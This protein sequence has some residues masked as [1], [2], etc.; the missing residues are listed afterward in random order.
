MKT[1]LVLGESVNG[2]VRSSVWESVSGSVSNSVR[3]SLDTLMIWEIT[4]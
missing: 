1:K 3:R 2:K 4:L